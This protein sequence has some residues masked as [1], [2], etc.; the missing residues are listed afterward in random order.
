MGRGVWPVFVLA[1]MHQDVGVS[2]SIGD[3]VVWPVRLRS[4]DE[5][6][7]PLAALKPVN[8]QLVADGSRPPRLGWSPG[9]G[10]LA[11]TADLSAQWAGPEPPG[12]ALT[13]AVLL[14]VDVWQRPP[15]TIGGTVTRIRMVS[16]PSQ[17]DVRGVWRPSGIWALTDIDTA[18]RRFAREHADP[19]APHEIGVLVDLEVALPTASTGPPPL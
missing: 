3:R 5:T 4:G 14:E 2:F 12:S 6:G 11:I 16:S 10:C 13:L 9:Q 19:G 7:C 8:V 18:T 1:E 15:T 17:L